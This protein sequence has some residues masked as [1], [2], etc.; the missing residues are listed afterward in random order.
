M[1]KDKN[2]VTFYAPKLHVFKESLL[3]ANRNKDTQG[4]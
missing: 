1:V 2:K 4:Q 3:P